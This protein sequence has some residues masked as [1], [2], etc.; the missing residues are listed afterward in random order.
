MT[1]NNSHLKNKKTKDILHMS[2][3]KSTTFAG[4]WR[5]QFISG[6]LLYLNLHQL[7]MEPVQHSRAP[8]FVK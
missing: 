6:G 8:S 3:N 1:P 5:Y 7:Q 2:F 4:I